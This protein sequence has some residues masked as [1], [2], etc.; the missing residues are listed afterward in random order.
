MNMLVGI[1]GAAVAGVVLL[2]VVFRRTPPIDHG[3]VS[4][5][6]LAHRRGVPTH[7]DE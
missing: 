6:W 5:N 1:A 3:V 2:V 7:A 4:E